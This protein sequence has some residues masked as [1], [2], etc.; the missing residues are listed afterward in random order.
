MKS[1]WSMRWAPGKH[2]LIVEYRRNEPD[3]VILGNGLWSWDSGTGEIVY[4][5]L[6]SDSGLE[7]IRTK[8]V[9]PG[10]LKGRYTGSLGGKPVDAACELRKKSPDLWTFKTS[11]A[12]ASG[13]GELDVRFTRL[14]S[15]DEGA[16]SEGAIAEAGA[17]CPWKLVTGHWKLTDSTGYAGDIV[18][19]SAGDGTQAIVGHWKEEDGSAATELAGWRPDEKIFVT[20]GFGK[21][22]SYWEVRFTTVTESMVEGPMVNRQPDGRLLKGTWRVTKRSEDEMPTLFVGTDDG[23]QVT[24]KGCFTRVK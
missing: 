13:L 2:C 20:T 23:E 12:A 18:W 4:H 1:S 22:G 6:Y 17:A 16:A 3:G 11:G 5:A 8:V 10:V 7:H 19:E 15:A 21:N 14:K 24:V 9:E